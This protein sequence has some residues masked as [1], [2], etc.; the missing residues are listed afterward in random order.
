LQLE[1]DAY[2]D[3][4]RKEG[5]PVGSAISVAFTPE[6]QQ[7]HQIGEFGRATSKEGEIIY[8]A[9][10][11]M[12]DRKEHFDFTSSNVMSF[13]DDWQSG[14][15]LRVPTETLL[16][17]NYPVPKKVKIRKASYHEMK[18]FRKIQT[19]HKITLVNP[20]FSC[21][22]GL[23]QITNHKDPGL[24]FLTSQ[25]GE[26]DLT[27]EDEETWVYK[28]RHFVRDSGGRLEIVDKKGI[29]GVCYLGASD[30]RWYPEDHKW[31]R[32]I[33]SPFQEANSDYEGIISSFSDKGFVTAYTRKYRTI[34]STLL[35]NEPN[36]VYN[37]ETLDK[38]LDFEKNESK[39]FFLESSFP[40]QFKE[41][42]DGVLFHKPW[43]LPGMGKWLGIKNIKDGYIYDVKGEGTYL[44]RRARYTLK[45]GE[46]WIDFVP[47]GPYFVTIS[48]LIPQ[49]DPE[50]VIV[51]KEGVQVM[52]VDGSIP[53]W[54][55]KETFKKKELVLDESMFPSRVIQIKDSVTDHVYAKIGDLYFP[56]ATYHET[57]PSWS[58][59]GDSYLP[60]PYGRQN[61]QHLPGYSWGVARYESYIDC[62]YLKKGFHCVAS[63]MQALGAS[64]PNLNR[65]YQKMWAGRVAWSNQPVSVE[66]GSTIVT[67]VELNTIIEYMTLKSKNRPVPVST[68][69]IAHNVNLSLGIVSYYCTRSSDIM[70]W[71]PGVKGR[72][73]WI[74]RQHLTMGPPRDVK[75]GKRGEYRKCTYLDLMRWLMS[76]ESITTLGSF[77]KFYFFLLHNNYPVFTTVK[78][79]YTTM[80]LYSNKFS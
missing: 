25:K 17:Q 57:S 8:H 80:Q 48:S 50:V 49:I 52:S 38:A 75:V 41:V 26:M 31:F 78:G 51:E 13:V 69:E 14:R 44:S 76:R 65:Y 62:T 1:R 15:Q 60:S 19:S 56:E 18:L 70:L 40:I 22:T 71:E 21:M 45:E 7:K 4:L 27:K 33:L 79:G 12:F 6:F 16:A 34:S 77:G 47:F 59:N 2:L 63:T 28:I 24:V 23:I 20:S 42:Q 58:L 35:C 3:T 32:L 39:R 46:K 30:P 5:A 61:M 54:P 68:F 37:P 66:D 11:K 29:Q 43:F 10:P 36:F 53:F 67:N 55:E 9:A 72:S 74:L 73:E 64:I